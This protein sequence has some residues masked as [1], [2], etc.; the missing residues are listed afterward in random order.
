MDHIVRGVLD[1]RKN[2]YP[3]HK[4]LCG[5]LADSQNPD[6]LFFTCSDSRIDPNMVTGS[7]P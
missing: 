1:F 3:Q 6:V 2:V 7:N 4:E 5:A